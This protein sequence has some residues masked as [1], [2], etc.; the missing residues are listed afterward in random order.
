MKRHRP[1]YAGLIVGVVILGLGSRSSAAEILPEFIAT[2]AGDTLWA[3]MIFLLIGCVWAETST[4][5]VAAWT[6]AFAYGIEF[7]QFH[8]ADWINAIRDTRLGGLVLG[9]GFKGSDLVCYTLGCGT[10][11]LTEHLYR[12]SRSRSLSNT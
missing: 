12:R 11:V 5:R 9:F 7:S 2:Y 4:I 6:L 3:L 10:G 1:T 8:Q